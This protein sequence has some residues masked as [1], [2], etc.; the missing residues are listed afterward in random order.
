ME[1]S[2]KGKIYTFSV[3]TRAP[4]PYAIGYV[5]LEEGPSMM[6]NLVDCDFATL[7]I[8]QDGEAEIRAERRRAADPDV[9]P[10]ITGAASFV[11]AEFGSAI[12]TL[13]AACREDPAQSNRVTARD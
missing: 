1:A 6:T 13:H 2:G 5:T 11:M 12:T 7:K 4:T 8:G 3:M 10:G 9:R